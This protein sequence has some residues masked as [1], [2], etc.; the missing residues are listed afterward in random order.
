VESNKSIAGLL[1]LDYAETERAS[2]A[3]RAVPITKLLPE[4]EARHLAATGFD[5][6]LYANRPT[7]LGHHDT[8][9][10]GYHLQD[11]NVARASLEIIREERG[12]CLDG[13]VRDLRAS[14]IT[15]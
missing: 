9:V 2:R 10:R 1:S 4:I 11:H 15:A 3:P 12:P 14:A 6:V 5:Q 8:R 13:C 7:K